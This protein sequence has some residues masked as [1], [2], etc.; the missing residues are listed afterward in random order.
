MAVSSNYVV[1]GRTRWRRFALLLGPA[2]ALAGFMVY[3]TMTGAFALSF[4]ASGIPFKLSASNLNV[5]QDLGQALGGA[6]NG[7]FS[8]HASSVSINGLNQLAVGTSAGSFKLT[9]L[10]LAASF[11]GTCP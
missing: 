11:T 3:L 1:L 9:D 6:S 10:N 4:A 7:Q 2:I 5:G 8:Q